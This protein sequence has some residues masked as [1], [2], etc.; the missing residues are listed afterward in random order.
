[1]ATLDVLLG[2]ISPIVVSRI[3]EPAAGLINTFLRDEALQ[4]LINPDILTDLFNHLKE[5]SLDF[6]FSLE[7]TVTELATNP[8]NTNGQ[9]YQVELQSEAQEK[10]LAFKNKKNDQLL[11]LGNFITELKTALERGGSVSISYLES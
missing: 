9:T 11:F 7:I 2:Q 5:I 6:L 3:P 10:V 1:M 4:L 8:L